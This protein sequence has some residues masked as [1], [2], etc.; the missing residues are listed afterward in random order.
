MKKMREE[1]EKEEGRWGGVG[2]AHLCGLGCVETL[3]RDHNPC[4]IT[5][6]L[7]MMIGDTAPCFSVKRLEESNA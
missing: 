2:K 4:G 7:K 1:E 6:P 5:S 3:K